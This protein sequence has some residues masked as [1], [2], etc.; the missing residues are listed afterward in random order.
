MNH[1]NVDAKNLEN[2]SSGSA[3]VR[4]WRKLALATVLV[5]AASALGVSDRPRL[6][7][8]ASSNRVNPSSARLGF[9]ITLSLEETMRRVELVAI[10]RLPAD[11]RQGVL[12]CEVLR[13]YRGDAA[14]EGASVEISADPDPDPVVRG[15]FANT[16][17]RDAP[18]GL[19]L[20]ALSRVAGTTP[21]ATWTTWGSSYLEG[22]LVAP[23]SVTDAGE[24]VV[25][26]IAS[27]LRTGGP[28]ERVSAAL[29][30]AKV[31][32]FPATQ[33]L[34]PGALRSALLD[35]LSDHD[36][37]VRWQCGLALR[38]ETGEDVAAAMRFALFDSCRL[39]RQPARLFFE[40]RGDDEA[41]A[42]Y[43]GL[44]DDALE[45]NSSETL[46][47]VFGEDPNRIEL[48]KTLFSAPQAALREQVA[49]KAAWAQDRRENLDALIGLLDDDDPAVRRAAAWS[50]GSAAS[51]SNPSVIEALAE[52]FDDDD[53]RVGV[54]AAR[55]LAQL[56]DDRG[57]DWLAF[58]CQSAEDG[59]AL[60]AIEFLGEVGDVRNLAT[61]EGLG[62]HP[63]A[64]IRAFA[65]L[66]SAQLASRF[67]RTD[68]E[69]RLDDASRDSSPLVRIAAR[70]ARRRF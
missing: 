40:A 16:R 19:A 3:P 24:F 30:S 35:G 39:V 2:R 34:P 22:T 26:A 69:S 15:P 70:V 28:A 67:G 32:G 1:P 68:I 17:L 31:R 21:E 60:Q 57:A 41:I 44:A 9:P 54:A 14:L 25:D 27:T 20:V 49:W 13:V 66:S 12:A 37:L 43:L 5:A 56:G 29:A 59:V 18:G 42:F 8:P 63:R 61:L 58:S 47:R 4:M 52:V 38:E 50:L 10:V 23:A 46:Q 7:D 64:A 36:P 48:D 55:S 33:S 51:S 11:P 62:N 6:E 65:A 45:A 53:L